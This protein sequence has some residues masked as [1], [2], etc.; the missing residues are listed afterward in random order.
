VDDLVSAL[1]AR[2][3]RVALVPTPPDRLLVVRATDTHPLG[4]L[5]VRSGGPAELV[6]WRLCIDERSRGYG[7]GSEAILLLSGAA[8]AAGWERLRARAH[9]A[10]GLSVYFWIRMGFRPLHGDGPEG[11]IWFE[12]ALVRQPSPAR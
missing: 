11:G 5:E 4:E 9:P 3:E 12:R 7:A 8:A 2:G 10:F 1:S 6:A